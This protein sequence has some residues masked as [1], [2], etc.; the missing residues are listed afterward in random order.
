MSYSRRSLR[1]RAHASISTPPIDFDSPW[2]EA[3]DEYLEAFFALF[4]PQAH[5]EIDWSDPPVFL[6]GELRQVVRDAEVGRRLAD[7]LVRV[8]RW[9]SWRGTMREK[10]PQLRMAV[11]PGHA[12][13]SMRCGPSVAWRT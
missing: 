4:L 9:R 7:R 12:A 10:L 1:S 8:R 11:S 13:L 3:L 5:A 6:D 2:T